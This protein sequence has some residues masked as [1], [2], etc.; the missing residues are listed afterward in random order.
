MG[1]YYIFPYL[2]HLSMDRFENGSLESSGVLSDTLQVKGITN[3]YVADASV[4]PAIPSFPTA[5]L[6]MIV[7][8]RAAD[9]LC[10]TTS[11]SS[12]KLKLKMQI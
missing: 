6:A 8:A 5:K 3:L 10:D 12:A 2:R 4:F 9:L 11:K 7:G 1:G